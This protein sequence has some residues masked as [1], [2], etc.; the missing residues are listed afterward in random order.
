MP[1]IFIT[2]LEWGNGH[3][4]R[5][6]PII[7]YIKSFSSEIIIGANRNK[8]FYE[9]VFPDIKIVEVPPFDIIYK[10]RTLISVLLFI[11][12]FI[13]SIKA[14]KNFITKFAKENNIDII[15]SDNRY[16]MYYSKSYNI[17]IT[18]QLN[19]KLN[20]FLKIFSPILRSFIK[21]YLKNF[22]ECWIPDM[23]DININLTG[24]Y[25]YHEFFK[26]INIKYVGLL[27]QF[28]CY[29]NDFEENKQDIDLLIM[30]S[31][32][33]MHR[34]IF[35]KIVISQLMENKKEAIIVRG[36]KGS[37][38]PKIIDNIIMYDFVY[39]DQYRDLIKRSKYIICRAGYTSIMDLIIL[40]KKALLVPTPNH[41]EQ[42]YLVK[43]LSDLGYFPYMNQDNF[44]INKAISILKNYDFKDFNLIFK[45][46]NYKKQ[47][48]RL[49][50]YIHKNK[51]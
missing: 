33:E 49:R 14:D 27:S 23:H 46:F 51:N 42:E 32:P 37:N 10:K 4:T 31:G 8:T 36:I 12:K 45:E 5:I 50:D 44:D 15:I 1:K 34:T 40:N 19:I 7:R 35:E 17:I 30:I 2:P 47:L 48:D 22:D 20:G 25:S 21:K 41:P 24:D 26:K 13:K 39:F 18:H 38:I 3:A 43:R 16:G 11:P 9:N 29:N 6:V 28:D